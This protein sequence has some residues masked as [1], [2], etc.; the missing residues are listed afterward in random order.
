MTFRAVYNAVI[1]ALFGASGFYL[2]FLYSLSRCVSE[3][4]DYLVFS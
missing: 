3:N 2:V 1:R 4:G